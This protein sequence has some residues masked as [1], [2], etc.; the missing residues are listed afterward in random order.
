MKIVVSIFLLIVTVLA[1]V[2]SRA[3]FIA[4]NLS[5]KFKILGIDFKSISLS[6]LLKQGETSLTGRIA[7]IIDNTSNFTL[8]LR[9][10]QVSLYHNN[11]LVASTFYKTKKELKEKFA[12]IPYS[13]TELERD[14]KLY[15]NKE[16]MN[17][18]VMIINKIPVELQ[19]K[20]SA[21]SF[22]FPLSFSDS[23]ILN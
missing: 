23:F 13:V 22:I 2:Y 9:N 1:L 14:A 12:I 6:D 5:F 3:I 15:I 17:I 7:L 8:V 20:V 16:T 10:I 18:T 11:Q 19:Y 21:T 4:R